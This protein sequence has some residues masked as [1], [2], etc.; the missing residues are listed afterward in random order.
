LVPGAGALVAAVSTAGGRRPVVAGKPEAPMA[1]LVRDR[2]GDVVVMIGDRPSTD[3]A[4]AARLRCPFALVLSGV[5]RHAGDEP[6]P[7]HRPAFVAAD[8]GA[9]ASEIAATFERAS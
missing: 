3:G 4:F 5:A 7:E 2:F 1:E 9:V 6:V 8:L